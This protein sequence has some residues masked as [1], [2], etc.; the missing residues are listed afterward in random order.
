[1]FDFPG[2]VENFSVYPMRLKKVLVIINPLD[3]EQKLRPIPHI[4]SKRKRFVNRY[5]PCIPQHDPQTTNIDD[6]LGQ[7]DP[8]PKHAQF[9]TIKTAYLTYNSTWILHHCPNL[10]KLVIEESPSDFYNIE[11]GKPDPKYLGARLS[12][13][14]AISMPRAAN[15]STVRGKYSALILVT[16]HSLILLQNFQTT[17]QTSKSSLCI[18]Q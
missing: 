2:A 16:C 15:E 6:I 13:L 12:R 17:F 11:Y 9:L 10:E 4:V 8:D 18:R 7:L 3:E 14:T 1:M 5:I